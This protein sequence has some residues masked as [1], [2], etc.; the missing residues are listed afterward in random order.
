M[1]IED[2]EKLSKTEA[3]DRLKGFYSNSESAQAYL[4]IQEQILKISEAFD[5][6]DI[7]IT[8]DSSDKAFER[9]ISFGD[10]LIK[11]EEAQ[12]KRLAMLDENVL[13]EQKEKRLSAKQGTVESFVNDG[14]MKK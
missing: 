14:Y 11:I 6:I 4:S 12:R 2:I 7:D 3:I 13:R 1:K 9:F 10:K 8:S 5:N